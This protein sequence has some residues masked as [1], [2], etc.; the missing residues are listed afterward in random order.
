LED[1]LHLTPL[2]S[3]VQLLPEKHQVAAM[4]YVK[5]QQAAAA[6]KE[7]N[8]NAPSHSRTIQMTIKSSNDDSRGS[9]DSPTAAFKKAAG[10]NWRPLPYVD[11]NSQDAWDVFQETLV[12]LSEI[13]TDK[14]DRAGSPMDV[15]DDGPEE[16][17]AGSAL[18][19][20]IVTDL[21]KVP[22]LRTHLRAYHVNHKIARSYEDHYKT[23]HYFQ[24]EMERLRARAIRRGEIIEPEAKEEDEQLKPEPESEVTRRGRPKGRGGGSAS[25]SG[26]R[27]GGRGGGRIQA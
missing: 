18:H 11:E 2:T 17:R 19:D 14:P 9:N 7:A 13:K 3:Y 5:R 27:R 15:D 24:E 23:T 8:P 25:E 26:S 10:E 1:E 20:T 21:N 6:A 16:R 4:R 12:P 22:K